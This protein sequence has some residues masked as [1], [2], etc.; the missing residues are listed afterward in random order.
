ML[1]LAKNLETQVSGMRDLRIKLVQESNRASLMQ[2]A[3]L[4][5]SKDAEIFMIFERMKKILKNVSL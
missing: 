4:G 1:L 5:Y 3:K 2:F